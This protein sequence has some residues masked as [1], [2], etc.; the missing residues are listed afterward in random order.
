MAE[1]DQDQDKTEEA[2]PFKLQEARKR[3]QVAK[4]QEVN[5]FIVLTAALG[6]AYIAGEKMIAGQL[7]LD[8][9]LLSSAHQFPLEPAAIVV[10]M[11]D[12]IS[13]M[14]DIYWPL[15]ILIMVVGILAN[16][17]QTGPVFS[18]FPLKPDIKRI[19]PVEGFKRLFSMK[20]VFEAFKSVLKL[21]LFGAVVYF[22]VIALMPTML[23]LVG[24][25]PDHY[26]NFLLDSARGLVFK[27][28]L[29]LLLVAA[30]DLAYSRRDYAK[31][32]RMSRRELK[33]EVK[34]REGDPRVRAKRRELQKEAVKRAGSL[35]K[36][37]DADVLITNPTHLAIALKYQRSTMIS[38]QVIAKGA[39][40]LAVQMKH[41]AQEHRVPVVE[42]KPLARQLFK[43]VDIEHAIPEDLYPAVAKIL[44]WVY[45][46]REQRQMAV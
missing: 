39:G 23:T 26:V 27:L 20:I 16:L 43:S 7:K 6:M 35:S 13:D 44:V 34:R 45:A 11:K 12:L 40:G 30:A 21:L 32:L 3:G 17:F 18:F 19:N 22:A 28:L 2:T 36:V 10:W 29:M 42:N 8:R 9:A 37:P 31:K 33:D 4:S 5:S 41:I 15:I 46:L 24:V 25:N 38:P 1:Q 14:F